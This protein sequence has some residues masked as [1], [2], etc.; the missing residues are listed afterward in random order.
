MAIGA[1]VSGGMASVWAL[2]VRAM[3]VRAKRRA[4][5]VDSFM[6]KG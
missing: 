2:A 5:T 3:G 4:A 1:A 6:G